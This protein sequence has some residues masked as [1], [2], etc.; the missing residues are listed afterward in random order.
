[1][2][3]T[4]WLCPLPGVGNSE[5]GAPRGDPSGTPGVFPGSSAWRGALGAP[6]DC[7]WAYGSYLHEELDLGVPVVPV[8]CRRVHHAVAL[9]LSLRVSSV[10]F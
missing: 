3:D 1:M 5:H 8:G 4:C 10:V 6:R 2:T 7:A 9:S